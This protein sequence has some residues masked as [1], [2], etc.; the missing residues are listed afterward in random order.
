[1]ANPQSQSVLAVDFGSVTT[2]V[3]L[4]DSVEGEYR[5]VSRGLGRTTDGYPV[6]DITVG[7]DRVLRQITDATGRQFIE[8]TGKIISPQRPDGTGVDLFAVT[9]SIGRPL[10][11]VVVGLVP[12]VSIASA[13]RAASGTYIQVVQTVSLEDGR[14]EQARLNA[15]LLA[16]PDLIIVTGGMEDGAETPVKQLAQIVRLAVNLI[17]KSRRPAVIYSGNSK[18]KPFMQELFDD[19]ATTLLL[20]DN[21]RPG[22]EDEHY[23]SARQELGE[24]FDRYKEHHSQAF[25]AI[26][27]MSQTGVLPTGQS[28][29]VLAE[30]LAET[31]PGTAALID[32]GSSASTL[33]MVMN[34]HVT[35]SI[36]TD[37]GLG[38]SAPNLL[39]SVGLEAIHRWLP[40]EISANELLN[41]ALNKSM[42]PATIPANLRDLYIEHALLKAGVENLVAGANKAWA[43]QPLALNRVVAAGAALTRTGHPA[44]DA[45][46][47]LD[48]LQ[49]MG[50][51]VLQSDP[52]GL[53]AALGAIARL[54]PEAVVQL[55]DNN[56]FPMLGTC[57]S[58]GGMPRKDKTAMTIEISEEGSDIIY[59][60]TVPGGHLWIHP[61]PPG[62]R[63][64][65]KIKCARNTSVNGKGSVKLML[66]GGLAGLIFDARGRPLPLPIDARARADLL[67]MWVSEMTGDPVRT[68]D[69]SMLGMPDFGLDEIQ[70]DQE[71]R[72]HRPKA[73]RPRRLFG[74]RGKQAQEDDLVSGDEALD[75][76]LQEDEEKDELDELRNVLS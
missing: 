14:D 11:A 13:I 22:M 27:L 73:A 67:P 71:S 36:R 42:R 66:S 20:A 47:L 55:V 45:L 2:R 68:L 8:D 74:R 24:A 58:L 21:V 32:V 52:Y 17:D 70:E 25:A 33:A 16:Y 31:Q 64:E 37:I 39:E 49:P 57:I 35:T 40:F 4:I 7:F 76:L 10:Q 1:M 54:N 19:G 30:Y 72:R 69:A 61:L 29:A 56:C 43:H 3:V 50:I 59:D 34:G 26:G 44:Y 12:D 41:Y 18:L 53:I 23:D 60:Q 6:N 62:K 5:L 63:A 15:I 75:M 46:L 9:A 38:H 48:A 65:V 51:T 28:Y